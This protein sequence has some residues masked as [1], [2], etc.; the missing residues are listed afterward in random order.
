VLTY[1]TGDLFQS[2]AQ[3]LVNAVNT[4]GVMG[5]GIALAFK[6]L[7]PEM[8][9][10]YRGLCANGQF[11]VGQLWLYKTTGKWVLN[12]PTKRDWRHKSRLDYI[13]LGLQK[14]VGAYAQ[15]GIQSIAFPLLGCGSGGL[16][17]ESQVRPLM[18][19]HLKDLPIAVY[20]CLNTQ[21]GSNPDRA[22]AGE[23][24]AAMDELPF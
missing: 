2:P 16:D 22:I 21:G 4:V 3:V 20:I 12:F 15:K 10:V 13:E 7:Y 19:Q 23:H 17:W 8:F 14:F 6:R 1:E 5:R 24:H 18:E 9:E 11:D